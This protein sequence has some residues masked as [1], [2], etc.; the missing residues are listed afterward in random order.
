MPGRG[1]RRRH[2]AVQQQ[3]TARS[4]KGPRPARRR[5]VPPVPPLGARAACT[6]CTGFGSRPA[7]RALQS[8][9]M[10]LHSALMPARPVSCSPCVLALLLALGRRL[11]QWGGTHTPPPLPHP[12]EARRV[13]PYRVLSDAD[14]LRP[15][16]RAGTHT[17]THT[18]VLLG[19]P[20]G[21]RQAASGRSSGASSR[22]PAGP[23]NYAWAND[24][25]KRPMA[26]HGGPCSPGRTA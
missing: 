5:R 13:L 18:F 19:G 1:R 21:R 16:P 8:R 4:R 12:G 15:R 25:V 11:A 22:N 20:R 14:A 2:A 7:G 3:R 23:R 6:A 9:G 24:R 17:H 26:A 10:L